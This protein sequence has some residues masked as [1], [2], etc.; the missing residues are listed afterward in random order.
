MLAEMRAVMDEIRVASLVV[1]ASL[2]RFCEEVQQIFLRDVWG[3]V[4]RVCLEALPDAH[5]V[6]QEHCARLQCV[7]VLWFG[8][9]EDLSDARRDAGVMDEIRIASLVV[10]V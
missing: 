5:L 2:L 7:C 6:E 8:V 3:K 1:F 9:S 10:F 4:Y